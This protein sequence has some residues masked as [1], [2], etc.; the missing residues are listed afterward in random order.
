MTGRSPGSLPRFNDGA[1]QVPNRV[2][3]P[4][5]S[6]IGMTMSA[7]FRGTNRYVAWGVTWRGRLFFLSALEMQKLAKFF[8]THQIRKEGYEI[9]YRR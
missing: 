5:S 6:P 3:L 4:V 1:N 8:Q 2:S 9:P 7:E